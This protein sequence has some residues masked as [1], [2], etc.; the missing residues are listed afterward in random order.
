MTPAAPFPDIGEYRDLRA[1]MRADPQW[2][3]SYDWAQSVGRPQ[4]AEE[5]ALELVFVICNSGM[6][7][8]V[9][10]GIFERVR[11]SLVTR[12]TVV[13]DAFAHPGKVAAIEDIWRRRE[14]L[15]A[16]CLATADVDLPAWCEKLPWIGGITKYHAAKNLGADVA[17]PDRWL[18]RLAVRAGTDVD[19]L[20]RRLA[21]ASG[22]RI[23][24]VDLVLWWGC[25]FGHVDVPE[26]NVRPLLRAVPVAAA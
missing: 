5:M 24:T 25:A 6:K 10:R 15:F 11:E 17:K 14:A 4:S 9:A 13:P 8:T 19:A 18:E 22:D 16:E 3:Q 7:N 26:G 2:G 12:G 21:A 20:C 1:R 23:A